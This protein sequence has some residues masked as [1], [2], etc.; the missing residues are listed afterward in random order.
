MNAVLSAENRT[1]SER[2]GAMEDR[3]RK[4]GR[5]RRRA[6]RPRKRLLKSASTRKE[7]KKIAE[8]RRGHEKR[9]TARSNKTSRESAFLHDVILAVSP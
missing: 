3:E 2:P 6:R 5:T 1:T 8:Q 9:L 4:G 7:R